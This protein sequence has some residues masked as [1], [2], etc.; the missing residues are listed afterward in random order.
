MK[1]TCILHNILIDLGEIDIDNIQFKENLN[2]VMLS[3]TNPANELKEDELFVKS[4][5][6]KVRDF[7]ATY[8][9]Q[10]SND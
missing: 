4:E 7:L 1:A 8:L 5:P 9:E 6:K 2:D 10:I 3:T